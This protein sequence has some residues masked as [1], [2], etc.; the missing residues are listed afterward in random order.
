VAAH[1]GARATG[2]LIDAWLVDSA[3]ADCV[4]GVT[5]RGIRC[6]AVPAMMTDIE[7]TARLAADC[8]AAAEQVGASR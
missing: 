6:S 7:T 5:A 3:D 1:Y 8:L 2:G 4:D